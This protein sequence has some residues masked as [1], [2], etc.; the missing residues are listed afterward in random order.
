MIVPDF[1][2]LAIKVEEVDDS[3]LKGICIPKTVTELECLRSSTSVKNK[4]DLKIEDSLNINSEVKF[5]FSPFKNFGHAGYKDFFLNESW[6]SE[7][8]SGSKRIAAE[9]IAFHL[10]AEEN[11]SQHLIEDVKLHLVCQLALRLSNVAHPNHSKIIF[12]GKKATEISLK[13]SAIEVFLETV[14]NLDYLQLQSIKK[15]SK[16][17]NDDNDRHL[18]EKKSILSTVISNKFPEVDGNIYSFHHVL[19]KISEIEKEISGQYELYLENFSYEKFVKKLE[20]NTEKFTNRVNET[21]SKVFTQTLALPIAAASLQALRTDSAIVYIALIIACILCLAALLIQFNSLKNIEKEVEGFK[22][23]GKI[24]LPLQETWCKDEEKI[25][26]SIG[27]QRNLGR[28]FV[29]AV[30]LCIFFSIYQ[31]TNQ[32]QSDVKETAS[33]NTSQNPNGDASHSVQHP[34]NQDSTSTHH[35][36][37]STPANEEHNPSTELPKAQNTEALSKP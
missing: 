20:E 16:W 27:Q 35:S 8:Y 37:E 5:T 24:P 25:K 12:F 7:K 1:L 28:L 30:F 19:I 9:S 17:L 2:K 14:K 34:T 32:K 13:P 36:E 10:W 3:T 4:Y 6:W 33:T 26:E 18:I 22:A 15:L 23:K 21:L 11:K 29:A 31:I